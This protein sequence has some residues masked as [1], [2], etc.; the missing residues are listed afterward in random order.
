MVDW[1]G[2]EFNYDDV[3]KN[4]F[5]SQ[6]I[7]PPDVTVFNVDASKGNANVSLP[8]CL[9]PPA[10][11][12][13]IVHKNGAANT[14]TVTPDGSD[15]IE[16]ASSASM[17][18]DK[19]VLIL[20][21]G[22]GRNWK[23]LAPAS[24]GATTPI[25]DTDELASIPLSRRPT[26]SATLTWDRSIAGQLKGN[27][28]GGGG[29]GSTSP[30]VYPGFVNVASPSITNRTLQVSQDGAFA[31]VARASSGLVYKID[32]ATGV[33]VTLALTTPQAA[34]LSPDGNF[35]YV[36]DTG[37]SELVKIDTAT[38]AVLGTL[39]I[40]AALPIT[41][42]WDISTAGQW[43][44]IPEGPGS[45][46]VRII[47]LALM[48]LS[49]TI[50]VTGL[51]SALNSVSA[52]GF[53]GNDNNS[54]FVGYD[55]VSAIDV[56]NRVGVFSHTI[57]TT[58]TGLGGWSCIRASIEGTLNPTDP[59][60]FAHTNNSRIFTMDI[61]S[62]INV[63]DYAST[64]NPQGQSLSI[65][66]RNKR[67]QEGALFGFTAS[68]H[69]Q[70][71]FVSIVQPSLL[72][73]L[74]VPAYTTIQFPVAVK[75][76]NSG[77]VFIYAGTGLGRVSAFQ[78]QRSNADMPV[79]SANDFGKQL[80]VGPLGDRIVLSNPMSILHQCRLTTTSGVAIDKVDR[81]A[82]T[83]VFLTPHHGNVITPLAPSTEIPTPQ[84]FSELSLVVPASTNTNYDV[85][86]QST[87]PTA[88]VLNP[89]PWINDTT[90]AARAVINGITVLA[91]DH[92]QLLVAFIR[93]TGTSGQ[94]EDS[95]ARRLIGN[96]YNK[97]RRQ[98]FAQ[99]P[100]FS[101]AYH[102]VYRA[103]NGNTTDGE[104]RFSLIDGLAEDY[105]SVHYEASV[106]LAN[107]AMP[108]VGVGVD[109]ITAPADTCVNNFV[110]FVAGGFLNHSS[111][112]KIYPTIGYHYFQ[113]LEADTVA[114]A[115]DTWYGKDTTGRFGSYL[116]GESFR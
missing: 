35:L 101:W 34:I 37:T 115:D 93:T 63:I 107:A 82:V 67:G 68:N 38:F 106:Q 73:L 40:T 62:A 15:K 75:D 51:G 45:P 109:S 32:T 90:P 60:F 70:L 84:I 16:G 108:V 87:S 54:I 59:I 92:T 6:D 111:N 50:D 30:F 79:V 88:G 112:L 27:V 103:A 48:S 20:T 5:K 110:G 17:T 64:T 97:V 95:R 41:N 105:I 24:G 113:A 114:A 8:P 74:T 66:H 69:S 18:A 76:Q 80:V 89:V 94:T 56:F 31:Y 28:V 1:S 13:V 81:T 39:A 33:A 22:V 83:T 21:N 47:N 71:G 7:N 52:V 96:V 49:F 26:D 77:G 98:H 14:V 4:I 53:F 85:Y 58:M 2:A 43:L 12:L 116:L 55:D 10:G 100:T 61:N 29:G 46:L 23:Q 78:M 57:L 25:T 86:F 19:S 42:Q 102:G 104:G 65:I 44:A 36:F 91:S 99:N 9:P 11:L 3:L 72:Q